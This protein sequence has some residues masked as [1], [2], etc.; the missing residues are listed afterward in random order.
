MADHKGKGVI[1]YC[2]RFW[3]T[4]HSWGLRPA[5][6]S[7]RIKLSIVAMSTLL[8]GALLAGAMM[9]RNGSSEDTYRHLRVYSEVLSKIKSDYVEE[10]DMKNVTLGAINGLLE[11]ID[12]YASYLSAE[13][14]Q[15]Y[16]KQKE[17]DKA[18]VGLVLSRRYGYIG[19]A[20]AIPGS[21]AAKA[22]I[23]TGD[24]IETI[25]GVSTRDMPLAFADLMLHGRQGTN[26]EIAVLRFR[27]PEPQKIGL[28]RA[29]ITYPKVNSKMLEDKIGYVQAQTLE[30]NRLSEVAAALKD[31]EKQGAQKMILDVRNCTTGPAQAGIALANLFVDKGL[32]ASLRGQRTE[33]Q[34]FR[35]DPAKQIW[36]APLAVITNRG[37][38]SGCEVASGALLDSSRAHL[39]GERTY[40]DAALRKAVSLDD[41]S[42]VILSVAKYSSP[43]GKVIQETGITPPVA[44][45][46]ST[47]HPEAGE[48]E[49]PSPP[50][51]QPPPKPAGDEPLK[52]AIEILKKGEPP[53]PQTASGNVKEK[54]SQDPTMGPLNIPRP[55]R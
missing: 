37:T 2:P 45:A 32:I 46:D 22:G 25:N 39:V 44:V 30:E 11:S 35:A 24:V 1:C 53:A 50:E 33:P 14:Y 9:S 8:V 41:G 34:E 19:V 12:P 20:G 10:P 16:L 28:T 27:R 36:K 55:P 51:Q 47:L 17:T 40:G 21:P 3:Y 26:V 29:I 38:A 15:Q 48:E 6:M 49:E 54:N 18:G 7:S 5:L 4:V 31:L 42:A 52:K 13:Q 43:L 23:G